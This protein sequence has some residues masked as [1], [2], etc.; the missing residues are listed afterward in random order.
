MLSV[1]P[2]KTQRPPV[3][4]HLREPKKVSGSRNDLLP[5]IDEIATFFSFEAQITFD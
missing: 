1:G 3:D 5:Q 2:E 4:R